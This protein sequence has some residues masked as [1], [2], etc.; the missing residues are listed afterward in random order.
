MFAVPAA[1]FAIPAAVLDGA[2]FAVHAVDDDGA[3]VF[4]VYVWL[5]LGCSS[6]IQD[7]HHKNT[8]PQ[9]Y[10]LYTR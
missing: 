5:A 7:P 1:V 6:V 9:P 4:A 10:V 8:L 2:V 3:G